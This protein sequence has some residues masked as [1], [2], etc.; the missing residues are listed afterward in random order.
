[1]A[2]QAARVSGASKAFKLTL[3]NTHTITWN[4][5]VQKITW[6]GSVDKT[7]TN[8]VTLVNSGPITIV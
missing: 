5:F 7:V 8:A 6:A 1:L 2:L 4:A 3:P